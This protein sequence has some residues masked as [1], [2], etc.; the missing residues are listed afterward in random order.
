MAASTRI[1]FIVA[2]LLGSSV[3]AQNLILNGGFEAPVISGNSQAII[4]TSWTGGSFTQIIKGN[5]GDPFNAPP[6]E[7]QQ[8]IALATSE[9][10]SQTFTA[11]IAAAHTLRWFDSAYRA[12]N[13]PNV[14]YTVTVL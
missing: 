9:T 4:P 14:P 11:N 12:P 8:Q 7:G 1:S 13:V 3:E 10:L 2:V 5:G 6:I